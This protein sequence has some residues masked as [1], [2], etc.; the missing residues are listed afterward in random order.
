DVILRPKG[1]KHL[2]RLPTAS[3]KHLVNNP[4]FQQMRAISVADVLRVVDQDTGF[5]DDFEHVLGMNSK[6][7][8]YEV[9]LL[10]ILIA[11]AT[12]QGIYGIAQISDRT[13]DQLSTIQANY[14]RLE[15]LNAANDRINNATTRLSI[16]KH[17]NIQDDSLHASADGQKFEA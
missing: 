16:F 15:T 13:Y 6:S 10:A 14:L 2:W 5:I 4:F 11:N 12:N 7:R 17:Y 8:Q 1:G 9:D 3:K